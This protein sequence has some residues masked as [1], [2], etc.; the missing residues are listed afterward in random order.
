[1]N[2]G[3]IS[4]EVT[5][6]KLRWIMLAGATVLSVSSATAQRYDPSYPVCLQKY[7]EGGG[8]NIDCSYASL[9]QCRATASGLSAQCYANPYWP[10]SNQGSPGGSSRRQRHFH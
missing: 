3:F 7:G 6:H 9:D 5:M 4:H 10:Q 8:T 1:V 2:S